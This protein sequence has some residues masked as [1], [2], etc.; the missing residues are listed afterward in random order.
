[1]VRMDMYKVGSNLATVMNEEQMVWNRNTVWLRSAA[2]NYA[3]SQPAAKPDQS[4][5]RGP[6]RDTPF[7]SRT[8]RSN[9]AGNPYSKNRGH[10]AA[11]PAT[12]NHLPP[13]PTRGLALS[14]TQC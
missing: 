8:G 14:R 10:L 5:Q 9:T 2:L 11:Q 12:T 6:F 13:T 7:E 1:M 3:K 4:T